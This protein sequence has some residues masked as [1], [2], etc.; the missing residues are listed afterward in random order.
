MRLYGDDCWSARIVAAPPASARDI[1]CPDGVRLTQY[2]CVASTATPQGLTW[3]DAKVDA[4]PPAIGTLRTVPSAEVQYTWLASTAM[5][6]GASCWSASTTG[7][8]R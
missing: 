1:T 6:H 5:P 4:R 8:W 3:P 2:R 7:S